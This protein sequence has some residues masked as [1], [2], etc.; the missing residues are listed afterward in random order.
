MEDPIYD[1]I[2]EDEYESLV[3]KR[4]EEVKGFIVDDDGIGY[5]DEGQEE[6][7]TQAGGPPLSDE[8]EGESER[9]KKKKTDKKETITKK[10]S[11]LSAAAALMGKQRISSMFTSSVFKKNRDD[12]VKNL[13]CESIVDDVI[14][15]FAPDEADRERRR[16][17]HVN[18][19]VPVK[20]EPTCSVA[21][22]KNEN[23][24][25]EGVNSMGRSEIRLA[26]ETNNPIVRPET[27]NDHT[28]G[29]PLFSNVQESGKIEERDSSGE[30]ENGKDLNTEMS[31]ESV[32]KLCDS[33]VKKSEIEDG[34][35]NGVEMKAEPGFKKKFFT[36]NAKIEEE[37][38]LA[39][40]A[41]AGWQA[42]RSMGNGGIDCNG[43]EVNPTDEKSDF[44]LD[45]DG[46]L[47]FYILDA[48]EEF[49]GA[50]PGN[51]Y[52]FGKVK[53]GRTYHSCC[54]VV[55]NMQRCVY[56]IPIG[57][58]FENDTIV[59]LE[60]DAGE[61]RISP[62]TFRTKLHEMASELK[63]E[64]TKQLLERNV[65][66]FSMAP[67]KRNYAFERSDIPLG[68]NYILKIN[69]PFKDPPLPTDLKGVTFCALLGT[70]C[71]ALEL[72]LIKRKIKGPSWLSVSKFSSCPAPQRVS[73]CKFEVTVDCPKDI[74]VSTSSK[75][76]AEIPPVVVTALNLKT[77]INEKQK[78]NEI[79]S[80]SA[81][82]C[83]KAKCDGFPP[84]QTGRQLVLNFEYAYCCL[85]VVYLIDV[86]LLPL[87]V[88]MPTCIQ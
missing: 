37:K 42:V 77:F 34:L 9:P 25:T 66:S 62:T 56:A 7:W 10:P 79:V 67:V 27:S 1:T 60:K 50:N 51:L 17:G 32:V 64:I 81:I 88:Y 21:S 41:T 35:L 15:E 40:S 68:E 44:E 30:C 24:P 12:K 2:D 55:K 82:C 6:D 45:S 72:F 47:P 59:K 57:S 65:S 20:R 70:H 63:T 5:G 86:V 31:N 3:A 54:V 74:Q 29:E 26:N 36:L 85:Y 28:H 53:V 46:S 87:L 33:S 13:S 8:S 80:A 78:V 39:L 84:D 43:A 14:A 23:L 76:S 48:H 11:A 38:D 52:L 71:S 49:Y 75:N 19:A 83:H 58:L 4:R 69:Y 61:S 16:R 18:L 73:W 22:V